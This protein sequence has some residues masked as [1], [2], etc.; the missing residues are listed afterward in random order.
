MF[1]YPKFRLE[2]FWQLEEFSYD[3]YICFIVKT[4][5]ILVEKDKV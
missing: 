2:W 1:A 5:R 4:V 3:Q